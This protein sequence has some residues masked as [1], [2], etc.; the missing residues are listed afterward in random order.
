[1]KNI[2]N[3]IN[4][5]EGANKKS[6]LEPSNEQINLDKRRPTPRDMRRPTPRDMR[7]PT[8][9]NMRRP[10]P[11]T[12]SPVNQKEKRD[13]GCGGKPK[14]NKNL[15][16]QNTQSK[17]I[18]NNRNNT[19]NNLNKSKPVV[20]TQSNIANNQNLNKSKPVVHKQSNIANNQNLNKSKLV[21]HKQ[22]NIANNQNLNKSKPVVHTQSNSV[23]GFVSKLNHLDNNSEEY[24]FIRILHSID[25]HLNIH[26]KNKDCD[27]IRNVINHVKNK[28]RIIP[29]NIV[30]KRLK[31][32]I[33]L[34]EK[35]ECDNCKRICFNLNKRLNL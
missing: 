18:K 17:N 24:I 13:C 23:N 30:K 34:C 35:T 8:P 32:A 11:V 22:S 5:L 10:T 27:P 33:S 9:G 4:K 19:N 12:N 6:S 7:R 29:I 20:H 14:L 28:D 15:T 31:H 25:Y 3:N 2:K 1:M 26:N 21:V 16:K